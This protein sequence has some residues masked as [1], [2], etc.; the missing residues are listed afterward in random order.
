[1]KGGGGGCVRDT[2]PVFRDHMCCGRKEGPKCKQVARFFS[3]VTSAA[4]VMIWGKR[5]QGEL[6][7]YR[8]S[9]SATKSLVLCSLLGVKKYMIKF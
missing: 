9:K 6:F 2:Q 8:T 3:F 4:R 5:G 1:M 7:P